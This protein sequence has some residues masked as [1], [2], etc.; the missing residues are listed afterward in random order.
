MKTL[1]SY[2]NDAS[3]RKKVLS[4]GIGSATF[5]EVEK[6]MIKIVDAFNKKT[7]KMVDEIVK[8][9]KKIMSKASEK[10]VKAAVAAWMKKHK[11]NYDDS[12]LVGQGAWYSVYK[13]VM[14]AAYDDSV[15]YPH[16]SIEW[17]ETRYDDMNNEY[18]QI[19]NKIAGI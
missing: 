5:A 7:Q 8:E 3:S 4:E 10:N 11:V 1:T 15:P 14:N 12:I 19:A 13:D 2:I 16:E 9:N 6:Q 17:D 18:A